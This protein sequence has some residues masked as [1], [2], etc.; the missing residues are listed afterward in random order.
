MSTA[1][2]AQA[3]RFIDGLRALLGD[4]LEGIYLHGSLVLGCHNPACSDLD[5]LVTTR[6]RLAG[7]QRCAVSRLILAESGQPVPIEISFLAREQLWPWRYPTPFDLHFSEPWR[8][9]TQQGLADGRVAAAADEAARC[10]P[11]LAAHITVL[12]ARGACLWGAPIAAAFPPVPCAD[13]LDS[14]RTDLTWGLD[15]LAENPVYPVLNVCRTLA[16][17]R[18]GK[19]RSK[20]EGG[21][22]ALAH[23]DAALHAPVRAALDAYVSVVGGAPMPSADA[24]APWIQEMFTLLRQ[25]GLAV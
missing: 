10:D 17:L 12:H 18:T 4:G 20:A 1:V 19:V 2:W 22:W 8:E 15:L 9:Q 25:E 5:L 6:Q 13:Y 24:L 11:D 23:L 3:Q 16:Y 21:Q 7:E 14:V